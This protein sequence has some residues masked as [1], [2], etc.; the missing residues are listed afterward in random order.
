MITTNFDTIIIGAGPSGLS[1][2]VRLSMFGKKVLILEK[3]SVPGGL[4]SYYSRGERTFDTGLH[5]MTNFITKGEKG[6]PLNRLLKQL[7]IPYDDLQLSPQNYSVINFPTFKLKFNNDISL[8]INEIE[9]TFPDQVDG[10]FRLLNMLEEFNDRKQTNEFIS[11]KKVVSGFITDPD[12]FEAIFYPSL[13]YGSAWENDVD[14]PQFAVMFK[15]IFIEG[16][17]RPV[18]GIKTILNILLKKYDCLGGEIRFRSP[19]S[20]ITETKNGLEVE[21]VS[22]EKIKTKNIISSAG[23]P[24]TI[25]F[26]SPNKRPTDCPQAGQISF[27]ETI[28]TFDRKPSDFG[29]NATTIFY[30]AT[31]KYDYKRPK[32]LI[33][34]QSTSL[35]FSNNFAIDDFNE[36][37]IRVNHLA[38]FDLWNKLDPEQYLKE[39]EKVY[40]TSLKFIK[41]QLPEFNAKVTFKDVFTPKTIK[42]Y[43][44]NLNGTIYGSPDKLKNGKTKIPGLYLSGTD[45]GHLGIVGAMLSGIFMSN[46]HILSRS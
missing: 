28:I 42:K 8:L 23:H 15:S 30:N 33:D 14:F 12:L 21:L 1:A 5:A 44:N 20:K 39:K 36:G 35:C 22:G 40:Q 41:K 37:I 43:T 18:G 29:I 26:L 34:T 32:T 11:A 46:E 2:G 13:V 4:N 27:T 7:R 31:E 17:S 10:F 6:K 45:Q 25:S 9:T 38:N 24:E 16:L 19:A 3:H